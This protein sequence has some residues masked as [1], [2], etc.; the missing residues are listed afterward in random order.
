[1]I[2]P[3]QLGRAWQVDVIGPNQL[4]WVWQVNVTDPNQLERLRLV[5]NDWP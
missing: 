3:N 5:D 4:G 2:D 1:M